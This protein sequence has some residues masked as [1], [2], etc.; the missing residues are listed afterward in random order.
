MG[1]TGSPPLQKLGKYEILTELGH[2][3]MGVV[4]KARDPFIGRLVA[5]KTINSSLVDR[6]ELLERFYQE[7]Q[8]AGKLQHPNIVTVFELGQEKDTP[9]IAME[10]LDGESLEKTIVRQTELPLSLKVGYIVR[11]CQALEYAHKNRV[12]HRDIKPGNIMVNSDGLVKVVDFGIARLVDF[13]RTHTNMMIGTPAYMAPELFRKKKAD[14]RTDIWAVGV[15]FYELIC[16]QRPFT[17]EGYDIIRSIMEDESPQISS[18]VPDCTPEVESIIQRMLRKQSADR[19]QSMEDVLLDLEPVWNRLRSSAA[20]VLAERARELYELGDLPGA[21]ETLRRARQ[22][23]NSNAQAKGLLEKISAEIRRSEIQPKVLEHL[24]RG[25][26][27]LQSGQFRE[28]QDEAEAAL[29]LDSRHESAQKL[30]E[31]IEAAATRAQQL[32]QKLRLTKQ[33]LAEGA[34]VEAQ[35]ALRQAIDLDPGHP[36]A[37]ELKHQIEE[38]QARRERRKQFSELLHRARGLWTDLKYDECLALTSEGLKIFPNEPEL[39]NLH[40]TARADQAEQKKQVQVAEVR[41]LLGQRKLADARKALEVLTREQPQDA[42]V[43][44][45]QTLLSQ[46]EQEEKRKKRLE[47]ELANL[48]SLVTAGRLREAVTKGEVLLKEFPQEYEVHDLVTYARGEVAQQEQKKHEQEREKQVRGLLEALRYREAGEAARRAVQEFPKQ[49]VFRSLAAEAEE[50]WKEQ[51]EREKIQR[52]VQQRIQEIRSKI[53]RQELTDAIDMA[54]QTLATFGPDTDVTQLLHAA[55]VEADQ[56]NRKRDE[57]NQQIKAARSLVEKEDFAGA[58]ELLKSAIA[59]RII[60]PADT[61]TKMLLAEIAEREQAFRKEQQKR[62]KEEERK[63]EE[64]NKEEERK[65][66]EAQKQS[67]AGP[68]APRSP[69]GGEKPSAGRDPGGPAQ[70]LPPASVLP[71]VAPTVM[72][73]ATSLA[74][75]GPAPKL[76]VPVMTPLP[77]LAPQPT[78]IETQI[79]VTEHPPTAP[80]VTPRPSPFWKP[81]VLALLGLVLLAIASVRIYVHFHKPKPPET[82]VDNSKKQRELDLQRQSQDFRRQGQLD[83]ALSRDQE[84]A[85]E[86]GPLSPWAKMDA[87]SILK[88]KEQENSLM[89]EAKAAADKN[90]YSQAEKIY[91]QVMELHGAREVEARTENDLLILREKGGSQEKLAQGFFDSGAEAFK[92]RD[93]PAAEKFFQ[94]ALKQGPKNW[95]PRTQT[96][97]YVKRC[98]NRLNQQSSLR[99]ALTKFGTKQYKDAR[100]SASKAENVPD[101]DAEF[102]RQAHALLQ[103]IGNREEQ[104]RAFDEGTRLDSAGQRDGA[105]TQYEHAENVPDGDPDISTRAKEGM[106]RIDAY[107]PPPPPPPPK[108][109]D[110]QIQDADR[111]ASEGQWDNAEKSLNGVPESQPRYQELKRKIADGLQQDKDFSQ[112]ITEVTQAE[113]GKNTDELRRLQTYFATW[114]NKPGRHSGEANSM[115]KQIEADLKPPVNETVEIHKTLDAYAKAYDAGDLAGVKAVRQWS[116]ADLKEFVDNRKYTIGKGFTL[117]DCSNPKINGDVANISCEVAFLKAPSVARRRYS[118]TLSHSRGA[119]VIISFE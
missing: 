104:K 118:I 54:R 96:Q 10:Y 18:S 113:V 14:E 70:P 66:K 51:L 4:Y 87:E 49:E 85:Q 84:I 93:Y 81:G 76:S 105:R 90:E 50:K 46:E 95:A 12:V 47:E 119:W 74:S 3:A 80:V 30:I 20:A 57:R 98:E 34:L 92:R 103:S 116:S 83:E 43:R 53:R 101:G 38:E 75:T 48:R 15:T 64:R 91:H 2:G 65:R 100:D 111:Y 33:R 77:T 26:S 99:V 114:A 60:E 110:A 6:P 61:Q 82:M 73:S 21:Q 16:Y 24:S 42:T 58:T 52:E 39:R 25:R 5:L 45:L 78:V 41:R 13:S 35:S 67:K 88:L 29:G 63:R 44:N 106:K 56:R 19:Y 89:T 8:S 72:E 59:N 32:D 117:M 31:E 69:S 97:Q 22:I 79:R 1:G 36:Q 108:N 11:I 68:K 23:D 17:G 109:Y 115:V 37:A 62:K 71:V 102:Q 94:D 40:E 9:F 7:A 28:A 86:D 55:E 112:K 27:F 107:R